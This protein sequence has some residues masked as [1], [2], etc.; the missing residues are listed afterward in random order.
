MV[1][2]HV[3]LA[4]INESFDVRLEVTRI[5]LYIM[6]AFVKVW[7]DGIIFKPKLIY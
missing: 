3:I 7:H 2:S 1:L 5:L 4:L 6:K